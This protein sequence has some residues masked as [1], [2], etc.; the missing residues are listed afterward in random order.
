MIQN[1]VKGGKR[2]KRHRNKDWF[3]RIGGLLRKG[4]GKK[5]KRKWEGAKHI[6]REA[7]YRGPCGWEGRGWLPSYTTTYYA[8]VPCCVRHAPYAQAQISTYIV[9][10]TAYMASI[11]LCSS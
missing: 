5:Q 3:S 8:H 7:R 1:K 6:I 9:H 10:G 4:R 11:R 2:K